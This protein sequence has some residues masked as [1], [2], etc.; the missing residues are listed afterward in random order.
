[1]GEQKMALVCMK[2]E[3]QPM[4]SKQNADKAM[5]KEMEVLNAQ[6]CSG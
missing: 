3:K 5:K 6:T 2:M 4:F 1:M